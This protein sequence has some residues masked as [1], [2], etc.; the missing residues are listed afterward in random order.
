MCS[1]H[2]A[3]GQPL[4]STSQGGVGIL[5]GMRKIAVHCLKLNTLVATFAEESPTIAT[6]PCVSA[7]EWAN[8]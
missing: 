7:G 8:M 2:L 1:T 4:G 3:Q 5:H 6:V